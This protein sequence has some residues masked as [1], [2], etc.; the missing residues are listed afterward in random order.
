MEIH[1]TVVLLDR[2][3]GSIPRAFFP[4]ITVTL[5]QA[6]AFGSLHNTP[7]HISSM[8]G[9]YVIEGWVYWMMDK[10]GY[11]LSSRNIMLGRQNGLGMV[12][13]QALPITYED[14]PFS[15]LGREIICCA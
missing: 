14:N 5:I 9:G 2:A 10:I 3:R 12:I 15:L 8:D 7:R 1:A 4:S 11:C 6:L 13:L